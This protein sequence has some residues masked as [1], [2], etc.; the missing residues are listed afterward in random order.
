MVGAVVDA[1]GIS[2]MEAVDMGVAGAVTVT[3]AVPVT[4]AVTETMMDA[5]TEAMA[6]NLHFHIFSVHH[7]CFNSTTKYIILSQPS[8]VDLYRYVLIRVLSE[9]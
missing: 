1:V 7:S 2:V 8:N 6:A 9:F 5:M 4:E 3:E